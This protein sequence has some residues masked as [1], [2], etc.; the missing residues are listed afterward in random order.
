[1]P[2]HAGAYFYGDFCTGFVSS[3]RMDS[4]ERRDWTSELGPRR[5]LSSFGVNATATSTCW[6]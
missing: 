6:S 5:L 3:V 4:G 1:M 2:G